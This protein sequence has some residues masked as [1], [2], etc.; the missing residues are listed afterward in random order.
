MDY[1][2]VNA[3]S[4]MVDSTLIILPGGTGTFTE[5]CIS[6]AGENLKVLEMIFIEDYKFT[7]Y[8]RLYVDSTEQFLQHLRQQSANKF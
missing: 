4:I 2:S 6:V 1:I 7:V 8:N 3:R 5:S